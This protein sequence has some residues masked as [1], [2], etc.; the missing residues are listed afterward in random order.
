MC[1]AAADMLP[2]HPRIYFMLLVGDCLGDS[3]TQALV[4]WRT[5]AL[6]VHA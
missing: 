4:L 1:R 3:F 5:Q 6:R 2:L